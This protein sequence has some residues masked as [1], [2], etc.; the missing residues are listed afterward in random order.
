MQIEKLL[1]LANHLKSGPKL[2]EWNFGTYFTKS[3]DF[4]GKI[5]PGCG[6]AVGEYGYLIQNPEFLS[7][8]YA[9][10]YKEIQKFVKEEFDLTPEQF[11]FLFLPLDETEGAWLMPGAT[12]NEV[13]AAIFYLVEQ[14][15]EVARRSDEEFAAFEE[16]NYEEISNYLPLKSEILSNSK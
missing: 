2:L 11:A 4:G 16:E 15:G 1:K 12:R 3:Y 13:A 7:N 6:C 5:K 8:L 10:K 14:D 9:M